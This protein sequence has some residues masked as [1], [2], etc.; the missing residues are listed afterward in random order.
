M[1]GFRA[2]AKTILQEQL[3]Y[4]LTLVEMALGHIIKDPNGSAYG[5]F[6]YLDDRAKMMQVWADYLDSLRKGEDVSQF[7]KLNTI[8]NEDH[9]QLLE[10]LIEKLGK[11]K[12][13]SKLIGCGIERMLTIGVCQDSCHLFRN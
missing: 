12:I 7:N 10:L 11:D 4:P 8:K 1:H 6:E 2:T 3:K 5:R 13:L 9:H